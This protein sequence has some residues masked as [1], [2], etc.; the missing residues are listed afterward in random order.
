[1]LETSVASVQSKRQCRSYGE[2]EWEFYVKQL[3]GKYI[4][5]TPEDLAT[6]KKLVSKL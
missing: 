4:Y 2:A 5:S 1:M 6:I 3:H